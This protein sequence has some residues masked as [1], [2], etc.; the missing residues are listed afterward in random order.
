VRGFKFWWPALVW[1]VAISGFSTGSF[2]SENTGRI[3]IPILHWLLPHV[4]LATL[5]GLHHIIRKCAHVTEYFILSLLVL[6]AIRAGRK[7]IRLEWALA[8]I[9]IVAGYAA[10]DEFHQW[11]VP[12]RTATFTDVLIDTAG[13]VAAQLVPCVALLRRK[14]GE[15]ESA[16]RADLT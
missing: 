16:D 4:S 14:L 1:A 7:E 10:L 12:G 9:A 3:I 6:R 2:T 11:F 8:T 5:Y 13:G 15:Q